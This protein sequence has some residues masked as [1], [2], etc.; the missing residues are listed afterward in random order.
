MY[1]V[2]YDRRMNVKI[3]R[4]VYSSM[5]TLHCVRGRDMGIEEGTGREI[6]GCRNAKSTMDVLTG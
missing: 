4:K 3:K 1:G 6:G 2:L 5:V